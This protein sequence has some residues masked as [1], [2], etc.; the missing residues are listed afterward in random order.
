[1]CL[2][3]SHSEKI[4]LKKNDLIRLIQG[5]HRVHSQTMTAKYYQKLCLYLDYP[6]TDII[7]ELFSSWSNLLLEVHVL[8]D[9]TS[10]QR[11]KIKYIKYS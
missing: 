9:L 4:Q 11:N 1:M 7:I 5:L 2:F 10:H 6:S 3:D 8:N